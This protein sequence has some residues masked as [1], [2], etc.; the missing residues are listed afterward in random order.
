MCF[1]FNKNICD[2]IP[3]EQ[4]AIKMFIDN[5]RC[6]FLRE[7]D[8]FVDIPCDAQVSQFFPVDPCGCNNTDLCASL[9]L[10][11]IDCAFSCCITCD[12]CVCNLDCE[13]Y[14]LLIKFSRIFICDQFKFNIEIPLIN[15][16]EMIDCSTTNLCAILK[17]TCGKT[18]NSNICINLL[19]SILYGGINN[20]VP[21]DLRAQ[22]FLERKFG[23]ICFHGDGVVETPNGPKKIKEL[24]MGSKILDQNGK[25]VTIKHL[26]K[27]PQF[28][29]VG[30]V[31]FD[32]DCFGKGIPNK[33]T[34]LTKE[35]IVKNKTD[36]FKANRFI[37]KYKL[38]SNKLMYVEYIYTIQTVE[39]KEQV[40][41]DKKGIFIKYNNLLGRVWDV[42]ENKEITDELK[43]FMKPDQLIKI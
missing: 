31:Q 7:D 25:Y 12:K 21:I 32:I 27:I 9:P 20:L 39:S 2:A 26:Y 30:F 36:V 29:L 23:D 24:G 38:T 6:K 19:D 14:K 5:S 18:K 41:K 28:C 37:G 42:N 16:D 34:F 4:D 40:N 43:K 15:G 22:A 35:H 8:F 10:C 17:Q 13:E 1:I 3:P 33:K 11:K